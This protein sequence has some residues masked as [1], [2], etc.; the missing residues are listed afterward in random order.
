MAAYR[1]FLVLGGARSGKS[2]QALA[3]AEADGRTR[4]FVATAQAH[5]DEMRDRIARHRAQREAG[6][7]TCEAPLDLPGAIREES[8]PDRV[9][10]VDCLTLWL[11]NVML[12]GQEPGEAT[13]A[14]VRATAEAAGPLILV[15]NEVGQGIVPSTPLGRAFRDAQGRLNQEIAAVCDAVIL[16]VAGCPTLIKPRPPLGLTLA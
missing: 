10:V 2:R 7:R 13:E 16:V 14:L 3:L 12:A 11:S 1:R 5:D 9:V 4:V 15:S 8:A 6:W